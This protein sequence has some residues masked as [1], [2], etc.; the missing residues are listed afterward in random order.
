MELLNRN[1]TTSIEEL[2]WLPVFK[3]YVQLDFREYSKFPLT[4][5]ASFQ[6][7]MLTFEERQQ[8]LQSGATYGPDGQIVYASDGARWGWWEMQGRSAEQLRL[9]GFI[10]SVSDEQF[11]EF[12]S[13]FIELRT[14]EWLYICEL[15]FAKLQATAQELGLNVSGVSNRE[16]LLELIKPVRWQG[17]TQESINAYRSK[18]SNGPNQSND[19]TNDSPAEEQTNE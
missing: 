19:P 11:N 3:G 18:L 7:C 17:V 1:G 9:A 10:Q 16:E 2:F 12:E 13:G 6:R 8:A 14:Q 15:D 5:L 4:E